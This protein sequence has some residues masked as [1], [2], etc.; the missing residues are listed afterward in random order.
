MLNSSDL[1]PFNP[2]TEI[3]FALP[4]AAD[5]KLAV[6]NIMGQRVATLVDQHLEAGNHSVIWDG[7]QVASGIY[8]YRIDAGD[9]V[10]SRK[11]VLLK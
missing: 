4:N 8:F 1:N 10:E 5:V 2:T 9:Y 11:M 3:S 7:S 6:F